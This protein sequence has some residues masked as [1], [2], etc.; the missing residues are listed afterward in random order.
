V[1]VASRVTKEPSAGTASYPEGL[2]CGSGAGVETARR[3]ANSGVDRSRD[4]VQKIWWWHVE[5]ARHF[6]FEIVCDPCPL[7]TASR[8]H[9]G[10]YGTSR[11][12]NRR[13]CFEVDDR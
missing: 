2:I 7:C 9:V 10:H 3:P 1:L 13:G 11:S 8:T 4:E 6:K 5:I 12:A